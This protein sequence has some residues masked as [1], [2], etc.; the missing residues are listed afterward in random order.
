VDAPSYCYLNSDVSVYT[1]TKYG[2]VQ[3]V[4]AICMRCNK[5]DYIALPADV[6][7]VGRYIKSLASKHRRC[8]FHALDAI[9]DEWSWRWTLAFSWIAQQEMKVPKVSAT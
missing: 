9:D 7:P 5:V 3:V 2:R 8:R 6:G 4:P 1:V